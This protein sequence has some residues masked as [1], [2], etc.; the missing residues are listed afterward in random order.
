MGSLDGYSQFI[1]QKLFLIFHLYI[2]SI[3]GLHEYKVFYAKKKHL[4]HNLFTFIK[5]IISL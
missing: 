2:I 5:K 1:L 4:I 3:V